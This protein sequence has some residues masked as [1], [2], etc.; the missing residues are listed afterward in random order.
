MSRELRAYGT[1]KTMALVTWPRLGAMCAAA[2]ALCTIIDLMLTPRHKS[3]LQ[4]WLIGVWLKVDSVRVHDL[5]RAALSH[6][7][8][9]LARVAGFPRP[10]LWRL[11]IVAA[12]IALTWG[13]LAY[14]VGVVAHDL[15]DN[16]G[17]RILRSLTSPE[18]RTY[19]ALVFT[20]TFSV[21]T[22]VL[23]ASCRIF[24]ADASGRSHLSLAARFCVLL[25]VAFAGAVAV[26]S[27]L[28]TYGAAGFKDVGSPLGVMGVLS[29]VGPVR[30]LLIS[31]R[32]VWQFLRHPDVL[33]SF[34]GFHSTSTFL[35]VLYYSYSLLALFV[36]YVVIKA[37]RGAAKV[38][39]ERVSEAT[40]P[41]RL[42]P[43]TLLSAL[44]SLLAASAKLVVE[45]WFDG[46]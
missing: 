45:L 21:N 18:A 22:V 31:S 8:R 13:G 36:A 7:R 15:H 32:S 46:K 37:A 42:I 29:E 44:F 39:L 10:R 28:W 1:I 6:T 9:S 38:I 35:L 17:E 25:A 24:P 20:A 26:H 11:T 3:W 43:F 4:G 16:W 33:N 23:W 19:V 30:I 40:D 5:P 41:A 14:A 2:S 27:V 12:G 34:F